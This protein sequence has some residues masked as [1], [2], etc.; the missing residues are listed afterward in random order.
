[1]PAHKARGQVGRCLLSNGAKLTETDRDAN[2]RA[3]L[4]AKAAVEVHRV[5]AGEVELWN[6]MS[7][8]TKAA[9]RW[10]ARATH[11]ANNQ[12]AYPFQD[13]EAARWRS[14]AAAAEESQ[15]PQVEEAANHR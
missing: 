10:I 4:L 5:K 1:M 13:S 7:D 12:E 11:E 2:G 9:A 14:E 3:D 6:A 15:Q 8:E